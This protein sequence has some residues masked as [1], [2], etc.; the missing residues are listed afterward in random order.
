MS[1]MDKIRKIIA[2]HDE[3]PKRCPYCFKKLKPKLFKADSTVNFY[4]SLCEQYIDLEFDYL[5]A[6]AKSVENYLIFKDGSQIYDFK[7]ADKQ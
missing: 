1:D 7:K 6:I 2:A 4:C 5:Y 3:E